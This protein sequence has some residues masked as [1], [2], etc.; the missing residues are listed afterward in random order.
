MSAVELGPCFE[1]SGYFVV[2]TT[3]R[4]RGG[5]WAWAEFEQDIEWGERS[6]HV[7]V[8]RHRVPGTF[9]TREASVKAG[10]KYAHQALGER[11]VE[12]H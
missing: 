10:C 6:I 12:I 8:Y 1:H 9:R 11:T 4:R 5:W 2:I 3:A 7:P